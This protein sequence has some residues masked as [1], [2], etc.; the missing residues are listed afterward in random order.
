MQEPVSRPYQLGSARHN[1]FDSLAIL[2]SCNNNSRLLFYRVITM[3]GAATWHLCRLAADFL[4]ALSDRGSRRG[5]PYG[6]T[7]EDNYAATLRPL[8]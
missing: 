1:D 4:P 3:V 2:F 8:W 7:R 5:V 6:G